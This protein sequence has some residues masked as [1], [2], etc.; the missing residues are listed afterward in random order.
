MR[1][2]RTFRASA[3]P[4]AIKIERSE[5][6]KW[7]SHPLVTISNISPQA[8]CDFFGHANRWKIGRKKDE[9]NKRKKKEKIGRNFD[10]KSCPIFDV[11]FQKIYEKMWK[12]I[13]RQWK[14]M[15]CKEMVATDAPAHQTHIPTRVDFIMRLFCT[16][17][18]FRSPMLIHS[19]KYEKWKMKNQKNVKM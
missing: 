1:C 4:S 3:M 10:A 12:K 2:D 15:Q 17:R 14:I 7:T 11:F 8:R 5:R 16:P 19:E 9:K 18:A 6:E 13:V